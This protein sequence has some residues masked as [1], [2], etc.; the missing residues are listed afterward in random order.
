MGRTVT[1]YIARIVHRAAYNLLIELRIY[2]CI[3]HILLA[4]MYYRI[5]HIR[6]FFF[7]RNETGMIMRLKNILESLFPSYSLIYICDDT[8]IPT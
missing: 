1:N 5:L 2:I 4:H 3:K 7:Y 6:I 8:C